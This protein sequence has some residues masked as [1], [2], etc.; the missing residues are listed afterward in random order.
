M[1]FFETSPEY[2]LPSTVSK[3]KNNKNDRSPCSLKRCDGPILPHLQIQLHS[4]AVC[5]SQ[6]PLHYNLPYFDMPAQQVKGLG[7]PGKIIYATVTQAMPANHVLITRVWKH[8]FLKESLSSLPP[9][10]G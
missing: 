4:D 1:T 8:S 7:K 3:K 5:T 6:W 2:S 10:G 9:G